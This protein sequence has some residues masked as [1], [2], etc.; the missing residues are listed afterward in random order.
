MAYDTGNKQKASFELM[1][2]LVGGRANLG[3]TSLDQ[4]N[5]LHSQ[6]VKKHGMQRQV[7]HCNTYYFQLGVII[8]WLNTV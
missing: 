2:G 7:V 6:S 5:Y 1:S 3:Y 8:R 4:K